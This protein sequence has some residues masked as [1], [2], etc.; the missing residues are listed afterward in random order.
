MT[1]SLAMAPAPLKDHTLALA[2]AASL[3]LHGVLLMWAPQWEADA[4]QEPP[5]IVARLEPAPTVQPGSAPPAPTPP[6]AE[7]PP[8]EPPKPRVEPKPQ[9]KPAPRPTPKPERAVTA[10]PQQ[11]APAPAGPSMPA[12]PALPSTAAGAEEIEDASS[13]TGTPD[14]ATTAGALPQSAGPVTEGDVL[15][16]YRAAIYAAAG[17]HRDYP[18]Y[19]RARGWEGRAVVRLEVDA[20]GQAARIAIATSSGYPVLDQSALDMVRK[21]Q[22]DVPVPQALRGRPFTVEVAVLYELK[23]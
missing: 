5:P 8:P 16:A 2:V 10:P 4:P 11:A 14:A 13:G 20:R 12:S 7:M 9:P 17:R 22:H 21:A 23:E 1:A 18:R 19:A 6:Q 3:L 15:D